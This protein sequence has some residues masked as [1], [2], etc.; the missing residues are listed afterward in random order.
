[1]CAS[2]K[3]TTSAARGEAPHRALNLGA[4]F[5]PWLFKP[6]PVVYHVYGG[7]GGA[8]ELKNVQH[9]RNDENPMETSPG[10]SK[11]PDSMGIV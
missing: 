2:Q 9:N 1:M 3:D 11:L 6:I 5:E 8:M 4:E 7:I 10:T